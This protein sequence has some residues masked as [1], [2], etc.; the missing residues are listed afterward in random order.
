MMEE[1]QEKPRRDRMGEIY[2]K[3]WICATFFH[4]FG[5]GR[6]TAPQ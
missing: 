5:G 2:G 6:G 4:F 3:K 1:S